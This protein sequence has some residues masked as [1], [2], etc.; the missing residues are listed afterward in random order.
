MRLAPITSAKETPFTFTCHRCMK[1]YRSDTNPEARADLDGAPFR[2][3]YC[4]PCAAELAAET[5]R[6]PAR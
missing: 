2:A 6:E 5:K 3:Y 4:P 1:N